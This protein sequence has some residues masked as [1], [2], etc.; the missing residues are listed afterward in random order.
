MP[1][2]NESD[3]RSARLGRGAWSRPSTWRTT[4]ARAPWLVIPCGTGRVLES[5]TVPEQSRFWGSVL[6]GHVELHAGRPGP[7][8]WRGLDD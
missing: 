4:S 1:S 7:R 5:P 8:S 2:Y 3:P 6:P